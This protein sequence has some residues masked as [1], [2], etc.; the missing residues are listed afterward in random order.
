MNERS[1]AEDCQAHLKLLQRRRD[2]QAVLVMPDH[3]KIPPF[4]AEPLY[5]LVITQAAGNGSVKQYRL[6]DRMV[7]ERHISAWELEKS[8]VHGLGE[9]MAAWM[10]RAELVWAKDDH[11]KQLIQRLRRLSDSLQKR[12][13][14]RE[15]SRMLRHFQ[16]TKDFLQLGM[17]LDAYLALIKTLHAWARWIAFAE[18]EQPA[19]ELWTQVKRLDP[20][21]CKLYEELVVNDEALDKRMELLLLPIEFF[22]SSKLRESVRFLLEI[23][24]SKQGAWTLAEL[25]EHPLIANSGMELEILLEKLVQRSLVLEVPC[26]GKDGLGSEIG[27]LSL[28]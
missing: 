1:P 9:Q 25:L 15:Y 14:C 2:V 16:E 28:K 17:P 8:A 23:M 3:L 13:L 26:G 21:V 11:T 4:Q 22:L 18:G 10:E 7:V 19:P 20:A 12:M 6:S 27:Y 5:L 24:G